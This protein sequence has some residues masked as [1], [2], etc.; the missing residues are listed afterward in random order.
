MCSRGDRWSSDMRRPSFSKHS[1]IV[2]CPAP[3]GQALD[4]RIGAHVKRDN[5]ALR[6]ERVERA[7]LGDGSRKAVEHESVDRVSLFETIAH[8]LNHQLIVHE[9]TP[10]QLLLHH[11]SD[12]GR[13]MNGVTQ[14][15]AGRH[16]GNV[17]PP[18]EPIG[19]RAFPGARR[20]EEHDVQ[21]RGHGFAEPRGEQC[22]TGQSGHF[23][24]E[25]GAIIRH[26]LK[27]NRAASIRQLNCYDFSN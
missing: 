2:V 20:A 10:V 14:H 21:R 26:A 12:F 19:L 8:Q 25:R 5:H 4:E 22:R 9:L 17:V 3:V 16:F 27:G 6:H 7:R 15:V 18:R 1:L 23:A 11:G 24:R 13:V